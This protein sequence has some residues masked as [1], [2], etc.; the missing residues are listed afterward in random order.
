MREQE[1]MYTNIMTTAFKRAASVDEA[2]EIFDA[3]NILAKRQRIRRFLMKKAG[4]VWKLFSEV[5]IFFEI[6]KYL[7]HAWCFKIPG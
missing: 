7:S 5:S 2:C 4:D 6:S 3:F 1:C